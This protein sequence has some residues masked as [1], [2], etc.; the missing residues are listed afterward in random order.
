V[1]YLSLFN[2]S[3]SKIVTAG[4]ESTFTFKAKTFPGNHC[5]LNQLTM[6]KRGKLRLWYASGISGSPKD[7][8]VVMSIPG[9][10]GITFPTGPVYV[11]L[12]C[13]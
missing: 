13:T 2:A 9:G 7:G 11:V 3:K 6:N 5:F 4:G 8:E 12:A 1:V 10:L